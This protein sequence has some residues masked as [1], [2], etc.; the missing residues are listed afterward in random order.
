MKLLATY[1]HGNIKCKQLMQNSVPTLHLHSTFSVYSVGNC[2]LVLTY[3]N[4]PHTNNSLQTKGFP[5]GIVTTLLNETKYFFSWAR[6]I[7]PKY[8]YIQA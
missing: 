8:S 6:N 3:M 5:T 7:V 1:Q 2:K 4:L